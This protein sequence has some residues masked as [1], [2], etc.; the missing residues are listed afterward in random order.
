MINKTTPDDPKSIVEACIEDINYWMD[1]NKLNLNNNKTKLLVIQSP[2]LPLP[3]LK[4]INCGTEM[5]ESFDNTMF[6]NR[7]ANC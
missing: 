2:T 3:P 4:N 5:I 1:I 7:Q 6:M